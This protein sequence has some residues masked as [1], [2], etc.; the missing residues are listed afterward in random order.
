MRGWRAE[1]YQC[2][3]CGGTTEFVAGPYSTGNG[4]GQTCCRYCG[5][6]IQMRVPAAL[7]DEQRAQASTPRPPA[8]ALL[9][10]PS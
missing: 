5:K 3:D 10:R 1:F 2:G 4:D 9:G 6:E 7:P 8:V